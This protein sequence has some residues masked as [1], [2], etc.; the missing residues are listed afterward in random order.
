MDRLPHKRD[1]Y[2]ISKTMFKHIIGQ[3]IF[4]IAMLTL[5]L[6]TGEY[7]IPEFP[8]DYEN[9]SFYQYSYKYTENGMARSGRLIEVDGTVD[10]ETIF[11]ITKVYSRHFTVIFNV[12]VMMQIFNFINSRKLYD[13]INVF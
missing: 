2:I 7:I 5:L 11:D 10:Y 4:Q 9:E 6:W 12:F 1:D 13:E 3:A 8:D